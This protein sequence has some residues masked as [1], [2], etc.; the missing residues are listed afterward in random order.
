[1]KCGFCITRHCEQCV[2][3]TQKFVTEYKRKK[4]RVI[5]LDEYHYCTCK[6]CGKGEKARQ[7]AED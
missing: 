1:M 7:A 2:V 3:K 4:V 5:W 6:A